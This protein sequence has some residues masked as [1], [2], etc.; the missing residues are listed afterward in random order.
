MDVTCSG[1]KTVVHNNWLSSIF[2]T[3]AVIWGDKKRKEKENKSE[4][5][6]KKKEKRKRG[7]KKK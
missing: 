6:K 4:K 5:R 7:G 1:N 2:Q 3:D